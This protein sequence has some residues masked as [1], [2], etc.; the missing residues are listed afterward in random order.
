MGSFSHLSLCRDEASLNV[1]I[2]MGGE[3]EAFRAAGYTAPKPMIKIA[4]RP[5]LLHLLDQLKL[6]LGDVVWLIMPSS[7]Y[8]QFQSQ[9]DF[10]SEY[11]QADIRVCQFTVPT[12]GA[13]ETI[14]I[15]LQQMST[16]ELSRRTLCLDCD[17][18]YFSNILQMFR[19]APEGSGMCAYFVD[20]GTAALYSYLRL[21]VDSLVLEVREKE[22]IS[23]LAN[24]GAYGFPSALLLRDFIS[25][26]LDSSEGGRN[27]LFLSNVIN[28]MVAKGHG[29]VANR[30]EECAPCGTPEK[31]EAFMAQVSTGQRLALPKRRF[32][33]ALDN[34]LVTPPERPGDLSTVR[35]IEKN[36]QLVRELHESGHHIII[37]T[38][39][40]MHEMG[41]NVGAVVAACGNQT[42]SMLAALQIPY[43]EIHFGQPFAHV[44]VDA[45]VAC[46]ALDTEKDLGWRVAGAREQ[47]AP[48]MVAARHFNNVQIEGEEVIKTAASTLLRGEI[49]F[50]EHLPTDVAH[51]FPALVSSSH[52]T[53]QRSP[54]ERI[55]ESSPRERISL[56]EASSAVS[57]AAANGG[58]H[59]SPALAP[60]PAAVDDD[61]ADPACA[62]AA[63]A[64]A[65]GAAPERGD[66]ESVASL[67]LERIRGVTFSHLIT[68]RSLTPGRLVLLLRALK[69]LHSSTGDAAT[70]RRVDELAVCANYLPKIR[71]RWRANKQVY[72]HLSPDAPAMFERIAYELQQYELEAR[73]Q[74]SP[75]VHGDPV[76]SNV[77]LTDDGR[78]YLLDM[79]GEL[80]SV[81]TLQ[82][83]LTYDLSKVYQSLLG[84]DY[85][86]LGQPLLERDAEL[87]ETL[88]HTFRAFVRE[89]Y[90]SVRLSDVVKITASHYF[91]IVP[92]HVNREHQKAYLQTAAALLS[93]LGSSES[94][95]TSPATA[96][97]PTAMHTGAPT[98]LHLPI[99]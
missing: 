76:F 43:D 48:G 96:G 89:H 3:G 19:D 31:L 72:C 60:T 78:I 84:Y 67:T 2:P 28:R 17:T 66:D 91:G 21:G 87:L 20:R 15:G 42:L 37:T 36:V 46:S 10:R 63:A 52:G 50:Y 39:R 75:V 90:P 94:S 82:G 8:L 29:F 54:R 97:P 81:L 41:G 25:P 71:K 92:L 24:I 40:L 59:P 98:A 16:A 11:P 53:A 51:L 5:M 64:S 73:W 79:R 74:H 88:R 9:L 62:A 56:T 69:Q 4:G 58:V 80:G 13:A 30:A 12:R 45:N 33:F 1:I 7:V 18:I 23:D 6:R 95:T 65:A 14:F 49:F 86:I 61:V 70:L 93:S 26:I 27:R 22:A 83:D 47:L 44:Y 55:S 35:P 38:S 68:N 57:P 34:V 32:C 99:G 85:I 77:L